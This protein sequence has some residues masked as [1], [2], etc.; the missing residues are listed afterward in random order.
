MI[1][2]C[3]CADFT[4]VL[5]PGLKLE[6]FRQHG[7]EEEWVENAEALVREKYTTCYE[8]KAG[9]TAAA[10]TADTADD[11]GFV[12]FTNISVTNRIGFR[13]SELQEYLRKPVENV[14]EPLKWWVANRH[15]YPNLHRMALDYL[16]I[17]GREFIMLI[18]IYY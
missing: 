4:S 2:S 14:K 6:Y 17:P 1:S 8:G 12:A 5:H 13:T 10:D 3:T 11:D 15:I 9:P 18:L 7:W 16:S